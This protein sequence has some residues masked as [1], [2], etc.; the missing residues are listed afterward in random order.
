MRAQV[1]TDQS[2][3]QTDLSMRIGRVELKLFEDR[4]DIV[5]YD[6][7]WYVDEQFT[8]TLAERLKKSPAYRGPYY[9][10]VSDSSPSIFSI[11]SGILIKTAEGQAIDYQAWR[12]KMMDSLASENKK[13]YKAIFSNSKLISLQQAN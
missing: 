5:L 12:L 8:E 2:P 1:D 4:D 11:S 3:G 10:K 7:E 13:I 6:V 9:L